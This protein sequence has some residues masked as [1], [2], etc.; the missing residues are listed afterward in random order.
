MPAGRLVQI[1]KPTKPL[2]LKKKIVMGRLTKVYKG[3]TRRSGYQRNF[4]GSM[5]KSPFP[6]YKLYKLQYTDHTNLITTGSGSTALGAQKLI[7]LNSVYDPDQSGTGHQ[8]FGYDELAAVYNRYKVLG[9]SVDLYFTDTLGTGNDGGGQTVCWQINNPSNSG[10]TIAGLQTNVVRE[11][12]MGGGCH[13]SDT[14]VRKRIKF[15]IPM[16]KA[17][18]IT[19]LQ[20]NSDPDNYTGAVTSNPGNLIQLALASAD[21]R[22]DTNTKSVLC[23]YRLTYHVIMYDRKILSQS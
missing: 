13:L 17:A 18:G 11:R 4:P 6:P 14:D 20:F 21:L 5:N 19:K 7:N 12:S 15:F 1:A 10:S 22:G 2:N 16:Y 9:C 23:H 3:K 8:P